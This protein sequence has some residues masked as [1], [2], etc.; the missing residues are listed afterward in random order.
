[1]ANLIKASLLILMSLLIGCQQQKQDLASYIAEIKAQQ[2]PDI[3]P[4]PVMKPYE[5]FSYS[6]S[7]IRSPF[8]KTV[9]E[10]PRDEQTTPIIDNG[11][12]PDEN[13]LKEAL[14]SY[15]LSELQFVGTL[16][17]D[18]PWALIRASDGV[19]HR[20]KVGNYMGQDHG[21]ILSVTESEL[22]LKEI[23]SDE[24]GAYIE[25]ESSLSVVD[26]N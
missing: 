2:K 19:I 20:V 16:G 9:V 11:I 22:T 4:I 26:V 6:A 13:R 23:V 10:T 1:M 21:Q 17:R 7:D 25:R 8:V 3:E 14:E 15:S 24:R 12:H 5:K 18:V